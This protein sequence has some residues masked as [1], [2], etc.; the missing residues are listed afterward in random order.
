MMHQ[1]VLHTY[2]M[3]GCREAAPIQDG[4]CECWE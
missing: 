3:S 4:A 2:S 1:Y